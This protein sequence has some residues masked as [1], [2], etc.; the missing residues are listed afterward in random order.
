MIVD[1]NHFFRQATLRICGSLDIETALHRCVGY[2]EQFMPA[3]TLGLALY[4]QD[5]SVLRRIARATPSGGYK[6]D[7]IIP[8]PRE[9]RPALEDPDLPHVRIANRPHLDPVLRT[10]YKALGYGG[11]SLLVMYLMI[12]GRR[13]GNLVLR[14]EGRDRY[15]EEHLRLYSLLNEPFAIALSNALKHQEILKLKD[16][17]TDDNRFLHQQLRRLSGEKIVGEDLGLG[18]VMEMVRQVAPMDSPVILLGET[19]V[20]KEVIANAIHSLSPRRDGPFIKVNSGAI[21]ETLLDSELFGHE[22]GAFTGAVTQ[23]R[24]RFERANRGTVFLD[25]IGELPLQAQ[26]RMLR[27]LQS[28]EIERVGGTSP[29]PVDIRVIA[30]THR[31]LEKMVG[32]DQFRE[33]LWFRLNVFP[34]V[35]PPLRERIGDIPAL[36]HHFLDRKSREL[37]LRTFPTLA[38]GAVDRLMRYHWPGNVR[39]LE[40]VVERALILSRGKPLHFDD[41]V[42][43]RNRSERPAPALT[44]QAS[45]KLEDVLSGHIRRVLELAN[46]KVHGPDG[47]AEL[48]GINPS[49]LRNRMN[50]L[51]ISYGRRSRR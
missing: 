20:G 25:E 42:R 1:E 3:D 30:A 14:V 12:E 35:I 38:P 47:A 8:I 7:D 48:L 51:G 39:E 11:A 9:A 45:L 43:A 10:M 4:E 23:K 33:D 31:D 5:F 21:P 13:L 22:R 6:L 34:I 40:N 41:V 37:K 29:I 44:Q 26:V 17:L 49:T 27:V 50:K 32:K 2:L 16:M 18:G 46:G 19:G 28:K 24:G 36:V 15:T